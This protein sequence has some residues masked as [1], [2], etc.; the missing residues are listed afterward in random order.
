[1]QWYATVCVYMHPHIHAHV[2]GHTL[3]C[4]CVVPASREAKAVAG[5]D[6]WSGLRTDQEVVLPLN[7]L[8]PTYRGSEERNKD[9][10]Q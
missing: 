3:S 5:G 10:A 9:A 6:V 4:L 8:P 1:M 7:Q 2:Q